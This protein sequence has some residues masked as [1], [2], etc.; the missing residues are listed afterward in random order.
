MENNAQ[1]L[2]AQELKDLAP[3]I[4]AYLRNKYAGMR[5]LNYKGFDG[6]RW[7]VTENGMSGENWPASYTD[8][9]SDPPDPNNAKRAGG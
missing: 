6:A 2:T 1:P 7:T 5:P 3:R 4:A 9:P 8:L